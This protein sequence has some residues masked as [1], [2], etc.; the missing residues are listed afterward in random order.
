[1][2][3]KVD[4]LLCFL[5]GLLLLWSPKLATA[6]RVKPRIAILTLEN[7][8]A[9]KNS[10]IGN[11]LTSIITTELGR[12][13]KYDILD[14]EAVEV[15]RKELAL[16]NSDAAN[17]QTAPKLGSFEGAEYY[18]KGQV[19]IF[20]LRENAEQ[21]Q[22]RDSRGLLHTVTLYDKQADVRIDFQLVSVKTTRV[23]LSEKGTG[24][25]HARSERSEIQA[26]L[27]VIRSGSIGTSEAS[28]SLIGR[29]TEQAVGDLERISG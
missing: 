21:V 9:Y 10:N 4:T 27:A 23:V 28:G 11:G 12:G 20:S 8:S 2:K 29:A 15:L 16:A 1:M 3:S 17:T 14:R 24:T 5:L 13:G 19:S 18:L 7:P 22:Q 26:F 25:T 6:Q